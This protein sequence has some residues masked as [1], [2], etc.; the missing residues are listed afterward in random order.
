MVESMWLAMTPIE[1]QDELKSLKRMDWPNLKKRDREK[2][3]K[4]Y[5]NLSF[6]DEMKPKNYVSPE[7]V[8]KLLGGF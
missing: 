8:Q 2:L 3:H 5:T 1:A 7:Q 4:E 6:P